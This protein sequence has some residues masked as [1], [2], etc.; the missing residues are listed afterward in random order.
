[1]RDIKIILNGDNSTID[2]NSIVEDKLLYEQKALVNMVTVNGSDP[3]FADRGT[4]LLRDAIYGKVYSSSGTIHIGNFA[5]LDTIYFIKSTDS[6][7]VA[8][9]DYTINDINVGGISYSNATNT[10]NLSVQVV[11]DDGT[12]TET[13][14]DITALS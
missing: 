6:E 5:A 2:L 3:I 14:A 8:D 7:S 11:Y 9:A 13:V 4:D 12:Y 10:L 1:M